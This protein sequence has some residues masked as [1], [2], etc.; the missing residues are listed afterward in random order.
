MFLL[1]AC[2]GWAGAEAAPAAPSATAE[3]ADAARIVRTR[4]TGILSELY[5]SC[6]GVVE[7]APYDTSGRLVKMMSMF[8]T[9]PVHCS[10]GPDQR[11]ESR[12]D[13]R[14]GVRRPR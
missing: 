4:L 8:R 10:H 6:T 2:V 14:D 7:A 3:A 13:R 11:H 1:G 12:G 5:R 9:E